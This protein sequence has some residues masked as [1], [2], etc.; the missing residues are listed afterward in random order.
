MDHLIK[1]IAILYYLFMKFKE[2][3]LGFRLKFNN[4][5]DNWISGTMISDMGFVWKRFSVSAKG[6]NFFT[7]GKIENGISTRFIPS[8]PYFQSWLGGYIARFTD[9]RE[10][11]VKDHFK[12]AE[13][14]QKEWLS[15]YGDKNM[16]VETVDSK[17]LGKVKLGDFQGDLYQGK[18]MSDIE[19]GDKK[20][21]L[22]PFIVAV[23]ANIMSKR[24]RSKKISY[25]NLLPR[26]TEDFLLNPYQ[27]VLLEGYIII[28][29]LDSKTTTVLYANA[30]SFTDKNNKKYDHF[31]TIKNELLEQ[32]KSITIEKIKQ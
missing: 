10:W 15:F 3:Q 4:L 25:R 14:D 6:I 23:L 1:P 9:Q 31:Q 24:S 7:I 5:S 11:T 22:L 13:A 20:P 30:C 32:I 28:I 8:S 19:V 29:S 18:I 2:R 21:F 16:F 26:Y 27:K 17:L 12:L